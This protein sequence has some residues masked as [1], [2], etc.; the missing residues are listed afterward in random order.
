MLVVCNLSRV[1]ISEERKGIDNF[2]F[3]RMNSGSSV[4][5]TTAISNLKFVKPVERVSRMRHDTKG[6]SNGI[7]GV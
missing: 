3:E 2:C 7:T 6:T 4:K 1:S 5:Y